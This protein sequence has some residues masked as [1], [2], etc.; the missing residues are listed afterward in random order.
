MQTL[1][2]PTLLLKPF[3][4]S[5]DKNTIPVT[6]T[7]ASNPQLAD[8][9]N[10]FPQITSE[11]PANNGLPPERKDFNGLGYLTT[12][13]D[14]FAQAGGTYTF[15]QT[16]SDAIGGYPEGARLW[17][18]PSSGETMIVR[19]LIQNNTYNFNT[20]PSYIDGVKWKVDT[21]TLD[22][23]NTWTGTNTFSTSTGLQAKE[24][25]MTPKNNDLDGGDII[26]KGATNDPLVNYDFHVDRNNGKMRIWG[27]DSNG[28]IVVPFNIDILNNRAVASASD[29]SDSVVITSSIL[30]G[31][32]GYVKFGNGIIIQW[33]R[34][35][36]VT[37]GIQTV[38]FSTPF[39]STNYTVSLLIATNNSS[40]PLRIDTKNTTNFTFARYG[41]GVGANTITD[42][43][44]IGY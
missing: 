38:N 12:T 20:D 43:L 8:L 7:D 41:A 35:T 15:N 27:Y 44:A 31:I 36:S 39:T 3:A 24:P 37:E 13:Y 33:G 17:Y 9:T 32:D 11:T 14:Y 19:S 16:V 1:T 30:K 6:N 29:S 21:P 10:G 26:F 28:N 18:T 34:H 4:E 5:G 22:G 25:I 40:V 23:N 42:W 2:Q